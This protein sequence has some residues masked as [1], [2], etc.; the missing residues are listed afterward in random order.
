MIVQQRLWV[1]LC[2]RWAHPKPHLG[3]LFRE[4][5]AN[6]GKAESHR[7]VGRCEPVLC[8]CDGLEQCTGWEAGSSLFLLGPLPAEPRLNLPTG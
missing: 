8:W 1:Y 7:P 3:V 4:K 6:I 2:V 5:E